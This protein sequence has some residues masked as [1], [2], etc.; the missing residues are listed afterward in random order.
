MDE[1]ETMEIDHIVDGILVEKTEKKKMDT[2]RRKRL[3]AAAFIKVRQES[4]MNKKEFAKWLVKK[5]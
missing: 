5:I 2:A 4:G 1:I 3:F